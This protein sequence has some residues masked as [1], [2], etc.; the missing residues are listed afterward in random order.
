MTAKQALSRA[1][2]MLLNQNIED[3]ALEAELL[4]RHILRKNRTE[5]FSEPDRK[6]SST[7]A[8]AFLQLV[9]R[10]L[11][12]EPA[13]YITGHRE[14][15]GHDFYVDPA[16]LIPRPE[17]ELLVERALQIARSRA[18]ST[19]ADI[20]TGCGAIAVSLAFDLPGVNIYATD[21]STAAL[22]VA[23]FNCQQY[24]LTDSI[25]FLAGDLLDPLPQPVDLIIANLPYVTKP[26]MTRVNTLG[27]EP[28]V[29]LNGGPDGLDKIRLLCHQAG[30]K[31]CRQG[32]LLLEIGQGQKKAVCTLLQDL[33]PLAEI[34]VF[35]DLSGLDRVVSLSLI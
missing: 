1:R 12:G 26:E 10:R 7:E 2:E 9:R 15:Y 34:E 18:V 11:D 4:L 16:V 32:H 3:S 17:S 31:L 13:A 30:E 6:L 33:F 29:A 35:P 24:S 8:E 20:G 21:I 5:L 27:F 14:F 22:K 25:C 23:R 19:I 28:S